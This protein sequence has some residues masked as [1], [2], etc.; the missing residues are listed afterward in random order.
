M[1]EPL[2]ENRHPLNQLAKQKLTE[3]KQSP[4]P[5]LLYSLDLMLWELEQPTEDDLPVSAKR[6]REGW[7]DRIGELLSQSPKFAHNWLFPKDSE[8]SRGQL[9]ILPPREVAQGLLDHLDDRMSATIP[10]W[11]PLGPRAAL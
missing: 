6:L 10:S 11:P 1:T 9:E 2:P 4:N 3:A 8:I 5:S 7:D